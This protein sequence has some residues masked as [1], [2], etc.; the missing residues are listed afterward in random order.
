M[1]FPYFLL[2]GE[3]QNDYQNIFGWEKRAKVMHLI[4]NGAWLYLCRV[5]TVFYIFHFP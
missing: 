5:D 1:L 2:L 4:V 3:D